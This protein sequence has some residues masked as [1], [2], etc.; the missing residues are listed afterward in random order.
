LSCAATM[1][2][3][4][5]TVAAPSAALSF[6]GSGHTC[7]S[8]PHPTL[9]CPHSGPWTRSDSPNRAFSSNAETSGISASRSGPSTAPITQISI[10]SAESSQPSA[11]DPAARSI[12]QLRSS[13]NRILSGSQLP[14]PLSHSQSIIE[15]GTLEPRLLGTDNAI[16]CVITCEI[17]SLLPPYASMLWQQLRRKV[18][19]ER[20]FRPFPFG[21]GLASPH[22]P[23]RSVGASTCI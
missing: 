23:T 4:R 22:D 17:C 5:S 6:P 3:N 16:S 1:I 11:H 20:P 19:S 14:S 12:P 13:Q 10:L 15:T 9:L 21:T 2:P 18:S 7:V 8:C